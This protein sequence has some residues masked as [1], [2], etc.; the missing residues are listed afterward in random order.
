MER[1]ASKYSMTVARLRCLQLNIQMPAEELDSDNKDWSLMHGLDSGDSGD[2]SDVIDLHSHSERG[3][4]SD[5]ENEIE[6]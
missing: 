5:S 2:D 1:I 4:D 6:W 3:S